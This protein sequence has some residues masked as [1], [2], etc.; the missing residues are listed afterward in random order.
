MNDAQI[1]AFLHGRIPALIAVY[2]FGSTV[3]GQLQPESD[4]DLA[5]LA[6]DPIDPVTRFR[7]QEDLARQM[8]RDVDL[9][10]LRR[11]STVMRMQVIGSGCQLAVY[12][13]KTLEAFEDQAYSSYARLNEERREILAQVMREGRV[14]DG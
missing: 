13:A 11:A 6:A 12:D 14:H 5:V 7:L 3:G 10:D 8:G 1:A 4:V 9:I 2:R